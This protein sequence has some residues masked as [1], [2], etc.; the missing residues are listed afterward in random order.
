MQTCLEGLALCRCP[1]P[2]S[3]P[4]GFRGKATFHRGGGWQPLSVTKDRLGMADVYVSVGVSCK[5]QGI[6][7]QGRKSSTLQRESQRRERSRTGWPAAG[8][9]RAAAALALVMAQTDLS[10]GG[11]VGRSADRD[12]GVRGLTPSPLLWTTDSPLWGGPHSEMT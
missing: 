12:A 10:K 6:F 9:G 2:P 8:R 3:S 11:P 4:P 7:L 1:R 5:M